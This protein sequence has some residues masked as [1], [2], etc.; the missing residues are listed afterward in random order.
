MSKIKTLQKVYRTFGLLE[1]FFLI[2]RRFTQTKKTQRMGLLQYINPSSLVL[3]DSNNYNTEIISD[4]FGIENK[5]LNLSLPSVNFKSRE[6]NNF[7]GE[8]YDLGELLS[9]TLLLYISHFK[10]KLV[11]ETGVAAGKSSSLIL[12]SLNVNGVGELLSI[13]ITKN[14]GS[15]IPEN[16]KHRW[17]L[18][19]L[20]NLKKKSFK[21]IIHL[22]NGRVDLFLHDSNHHPHWQIF[23]VKTILQANK[24]I[25][26]LFIDDVSV[27]FIE[28]MKSQYLSFELLLL[29]E[30][31][32][33]SCVAFRKI[34]DH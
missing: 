8:E 19:I 25:S 20:K 13:D 14:V 5:V 10:P 27:E 3:L 21:R 24:N 22:F 16:V 1:V 2:I 11:L 12:N 7:F 9:T 32:K 28:L 6:T 26:V 23:E 31:K 15:L 34:N 33:F 4:F 29:N 17:K 30:G 18:F